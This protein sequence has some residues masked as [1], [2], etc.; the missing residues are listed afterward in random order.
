MLFA[1]RRRREESAWWVGAA[2]GWLPV[3]Q[4]G[5][6]FIHPMADRYLY[7]ALPGLIGGC[8]FAARDAL[9][10]HGRRLRCGR[11]AR[12]QRRGPAAALF[13]WR[14]VRACGARP[15][16]SRWRRPPGSPTGS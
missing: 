3:A 6:T 4:I 8:G 2:A 9:R 10:R 14:S 15:S 1:M 16:R 11:A 12:N 7:F 13:A 5:T